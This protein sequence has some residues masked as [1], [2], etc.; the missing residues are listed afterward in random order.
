MIFTQNLKHESFRLEEIGTSLSDKFYFYDVHRYK[1]LDHYL[2]LYTLDKPDKFLWFKRRK[3]LGRL[4]IELHEKQSIIFVCTT[5]VEFGDQIDKIL[6]ALYKN[7]IV[8]VQ[9]ETYVS[10]YGFFS[11]TNKMIKEFLEEKKKNAN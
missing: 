11:L 2:E 4:S 5:S 1:G 3:F 7:V 8:S 6:S 10:I 9:D